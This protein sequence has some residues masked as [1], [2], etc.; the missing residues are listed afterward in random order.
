M[1]NLHVHT[2]I[3]AVF[4]SCSVGSRVEK[5]GDENLDVSHAPSAGE[6]CAQTT[7]STL[8]HLKELT[9]D[10]RT[11][12]AECSGAEQD[13]IPQGDA[14]RMETFATGTLM[15]DLKDLIEDCEEEQKT[16]EYAEFV[17]EAKQY[18]Q[19]S[20]FVPKLKEVAP[21]L[22]ALKAAMLPDEKQETT[23]TTV[24]DEVINQ[25]ITRQANDVMTKLGESGDEMPMHLKLY[26]H[27]NEANGGFHADKDG[28]K[29]LPFLTSDYIHGQPPKFGGFKGVV[30]WDDLNIYDFESVN[31]I[32]E[33]AEFK[34]RGRRHSRAGACSD[35][36]SRLFAF[37]ITR[38]PVLGETRGKE[39]IS[40][41]S[42][43][44]SSVQALDPVLES[45]TS[46][47]VFAMIRCGE[48]DR[49]GKGH[50]CF[51]PEDPIEPVLYGFRKALP[52]ELGVC[53][54]WVDPETH[55]RKLS[56]AAQ[57]YAVHMS[58][59]EEKPAGSN[60]SSYLL[61]TSMSP[62]SLIQQGSGAK[63]G[64]A[65][66]TVGAILGTM[67]RASA[68]V[69]E[70]SMTIVDFIVRASFGLIT[71]IAGLGLDIAFLPLAPLLGKNHNRKRQKM[72]EFFLGIA[73]MPLCLVTTI[74]SVLSWSV[75]A[76]TYLLKHVAFFLPGNTQRSMQGTV[77]QSESGQ[78]VKCFGKRLPGSYM[79]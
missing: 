12:L 65:I 27:Y 18:A 9:D 54:P 39:N 13:C 8:A 3:F 38:N 43:G 78:M 37:A 45:L 64:Q 15:E 53:L 1:A 74:Y 76:A 69:I 67:L 44:Q 30:G 42:P 73:A 14:K 77:Q 56:C 35:A 33:S 50:T 72:K 57:A 55:M 41:E 28:N 7:R 10:V 52:G 68:F 4:V 17:E 47:H 22:Q 66:M 60:V 26:C 16:P 29:F 23:L 25:A 32:F 48:G 61:E 31:A 75:F 51:M 79:G 5:V 6:A 36:N 62:G 24:G 49:V 11:M 63:W 58:K 19:V 34:V 59:Y 46:E 20:G 2:A 21:E 40:F 71:F 70:L